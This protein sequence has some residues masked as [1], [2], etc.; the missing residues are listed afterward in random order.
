M[1]SLQSVFDV[2]ISG[3]ESPYTL[4]I[5]YGDGNTET[6]TVT[7]HSH[8]FVHEYTEFGSYVVNVNVTS[9]SGLGFKQL[10]IA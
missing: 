9:E 6:A 2:N 1:D 4:E 5:D 8:T 10:S 3:D 7:S